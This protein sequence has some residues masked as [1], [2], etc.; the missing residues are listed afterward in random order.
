MIL[1]DCVSV[2]SISHMHQLATQCGTV[3]SLHQQTHG[4]RTSSAAWN[5]TDSVEAAQTKLGSF[6]YIALRLG[7]PHSI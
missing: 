1:S 2:I 6:S 5:G 4:L 3:S 7:R